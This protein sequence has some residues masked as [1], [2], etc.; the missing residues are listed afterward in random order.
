MEQLYPTLLRIPV[1]VW[2]KGKGEEYVVSVLAYACKDELKKV[3]E[4]GMLI[5]NRNFVQLA[6]LVSL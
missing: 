1:A 3:V 2:A 6:E 4:D 5:R